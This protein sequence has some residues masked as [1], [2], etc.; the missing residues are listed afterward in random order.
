MY[1]SAKNFS[2]KVKTKK[3]REVRAK[4]KPHK[5]PFI[6]KPT[7]KEDLLPPVKLR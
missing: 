7:L 6:G 3:L 2:T 1:K 4:L 5:A